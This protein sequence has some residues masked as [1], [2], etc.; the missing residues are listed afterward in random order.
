MLVKPINGIVVL[1]FS[2]ETKSRLMS[3]SPFVSK[4]RDTAFLKAKH[5]ITS[6]LQRV[7]VTLQH[8][9]S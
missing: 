9:I 7:G 6:V 8:L 1:K 3:Q 2:P 5:I 4:L